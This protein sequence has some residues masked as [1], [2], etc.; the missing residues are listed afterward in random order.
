MPAGDGYFDG[1]GRR[2]HYRWWS[3]DDPEWVVLFAPGFGD[4]SG[5]WARYGETLAAHGGAVLAVDHRGHG[6]S[7]GDRAVVEDFDVVAEEFLR[8]RDVPEYPAG[9]PMLLA[10]HSMGGI[11][12]ARAA[13]TGDADPVGLAISGARLG[14]WP[15]ADEL[16]ERIERGE[17]APEAGQGHPLLDPRTDIP[18]DALSRDTSIVEQFKND[19]LSYKGAYPVQTLFA[20]VRAQKQLEDADEGALGFPIIYIHGGGDYITPFRG[21]VQRLAQLSDGDLEVRIFAGARHSIFNEIN[22]DE[23]YAT[24]IAFIR[25]V[26]G[27]QEQ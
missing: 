19:E 6:L 22:R 9:I 24:L 10:G 15:T 7:E 12:V 8:L 5:R 21:S 1:S 2:L 4:H 16:V 27:G 18:P 26:T 13:L 17:P 20:Y 11:V 14:R 23:I 3:A 25:R